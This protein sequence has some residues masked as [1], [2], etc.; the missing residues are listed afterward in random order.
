[1]IRLDTA[2]PGLPF[3]GLFAGRNLPRFCLPRGLEGPGTSLE[4]GASRSGESRASNR[5]DELALGQQR[6]DGV[7]V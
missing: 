6:N 4:T 7:K 1:M 2:V 3:I 5:V